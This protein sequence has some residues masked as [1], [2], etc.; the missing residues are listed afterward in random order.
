MIPVED[1][2]GIYKRG[3]R[4]VVKWKHRG[5]QHKSYHRTLSEAR[6][7]KAKRAS[8]D[9]EPVVRQR[10]DVY[11]RAWV[12]SYQ[13]RTRRGIGDSTRASYRDAIERVA[14]PY[15]RGTR[16]GDIRASDMRDYVE[17]LRKL[18]TKRGKRGKPQ[19]LT[20]ATIRRYVAPLRAMFAEAAGDGLLP[21]NPTSSVRVFVRGEQRRRPRTLTPEQILAL[22]EAIP[23]EH[24]DVVA[25]LAHTGVRISEALAATWGDLVLEDGAPVLRIPDSKTD[26]GVRSVPLSPEFNRRLVRRRAAAKYAT[27]ADPI[28]PSAVGTPMERRNFNWRVWQPAIEAAGVEATPHTLRHSLAS[29][30][31]ERG[32]TAAQIAALLGHSD[33]S[34]TLR[35]YVHA[36]ELGDVSFLDD[37]FGGE[38]G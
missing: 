36:R 3:N 17:H 1:H 22:V 32:H 38:S 13:G 34:F 8:G 30:L 19:P 35:T 27:D 33:P 25:F 24:R 5:R 21:T 4:Y 18:K 16:L 29:L 20:S 31:F 15:F 12:E 10:F 6:R 37:V 23:A 9:T 28:F 11:A 7:A 14:I 26:A 2:P